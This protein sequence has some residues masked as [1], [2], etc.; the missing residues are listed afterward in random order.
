[1]CA[2]QHTILLLVRLKCK[3]TEPEAVSCVCLESALDSRRIL[4]LPGTAVPTSS[5]THRRKEI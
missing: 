1:V 4:S 2:I 5:H 3:V